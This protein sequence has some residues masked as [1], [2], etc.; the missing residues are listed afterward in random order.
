MRKFN[1]ILQHDSMQCGAACLTM[2]CNYYG[3]P[4][5]L[6]EVSDMCPATT[7]GVSLYG[8]SETAKHIGF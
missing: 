4:Y 2:V 3:L 1:C 8:M 7:E 6:E 5:L